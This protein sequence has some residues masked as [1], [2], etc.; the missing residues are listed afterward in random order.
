MPLTRVHLLGAAD[1]LGAFLVRTGLDVVDGLDGTTDGSAVVVV[2]DRLDEPLEDRLLAVGVP[3]LLV[4][5]TMSTALSDAA[6]LVPR[7]LTP[8]HEVR[9][10]PGRDAGEVAARRGGDLLLHDRWP[11]QDKVADDVE[12]LLTASS[13]FRD[14]PVATWRPSTRVGA[15]TVGSTATTLAD[16]VWHRLVHRVL[17]HVTGVRDGGPVRFGM[18]GF[19]AIG[20]EHAAAVARTEGLEL[21][22]VCDTDPARTDAA[23]SVAP[24][25]RVHTGADALLTDDGVD[26]VVVSTPPSTHAHWVLQAL[27]AGKHVVVEK[28]FCLTV[29]QADRQVAAAAE[30]RL[31]LAVY[32]NRRWDADYLA[33]KRVVRDGLV[34]EVFSV[35]TFVGGYGHPCNFWHSD[36][37]VSGGAVYDWGSHYLDQL[38]DL[39]GTD[40]EWVSATA[41]KRVWHDVTNADHTRVLLHYRDGREAEFTASDLAAARKPKYHVLGTRGAVVGD[42]REERV[43]SRSA[44]GLLLEDRL[45]PADSPA[46]L[47][48]L[49]PDGAGGTSVTAL[50]VPPPP[51][52]PFHRELA[53]ALLAGV[54]MSVTPEG[55]RRGVAVME[56]ATRSA[57]DGGRP[58]DV[59]L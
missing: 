32:Q 51:L 44:V 26:L 1:D 30:R 8:V 45:A 57:Q 2:A 14:H 59:D 22:A 49:V 31:L 58:V 54:P 19:G 11:L 6:G 15:L 28:P 38:L 52:D 42:W 17:R 13:A 53:D 18:L 9:V 46:A 21:A 39:L 20:L 43:V 35:E 5:P 24:E 50:S 34:G 7:E 56:A 37:A 23:R 33:L 4:G 47:R 27:E 3:V 48:V 25:V 41:H 29:E 16:P 10:R 40:V 36:E 12:V 55:S